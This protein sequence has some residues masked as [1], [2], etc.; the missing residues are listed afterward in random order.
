MHEPATWEVFDETCPLL[1]LHYSPQRVRMLAFGL[2]NGQLCAVSPAS[3]MVDAQFEALQAWGR[4]RFLLAPNHFHSAGLASWHARFPDAQVVANPRALPRLRKK[5][6]GT[7]MADLTQLELALPPGI[8]IF[9]PPMAKQGETW[10][11]VRTSTA[12]T[13][14]I[15]D[16]ILN[17]RRLPGGPLGLLMKA[18]GFRAELMTNPFFKRFFLH[19]KSAYKA[20]L[21]AELDRDPPDVLIPSHGDVL[22]GPDLVARLRAITLAA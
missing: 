12:T 10:V 11:S 22:R 2:G 9:G 17:E 14:F 18:I 19:S 4:P 6:P 3:G 15:T 21:L 1:G 8:R 20:W 16:A 5:V 13:W 7:A